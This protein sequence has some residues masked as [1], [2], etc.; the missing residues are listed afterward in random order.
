MN[1]RYYNKIVDEIFELNMGRRVKDKFINEY[2]EIE[3]NAIIVYIDEN[4]L[5]VAKR[6][7]NFLIHYSKIK[8]SINE[9][10][11]ISNLLFKGRGVFEKNLKENLLLKIIKNLKAKN[12]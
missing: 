9:I 10:P 2:G 6:G 1:E 11:F 7:K 12:A 4:N 8:K 5:T 3:R